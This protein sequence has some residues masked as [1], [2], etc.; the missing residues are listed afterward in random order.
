VGSVS[1]LMA[2]DYTI[3]NLR[4]DYAVSDQVKVFARVDNLFNLHYQNRTGLLAPGLG[5]F[6]GIR[7]AARVDW[8]MIRKSEDRFSEKIILK[9]KG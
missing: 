7:V 3:V 6:G 1:G 5:V 9:L 2:P 4:G 8:S